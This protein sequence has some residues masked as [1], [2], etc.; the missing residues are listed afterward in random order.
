MF[1]ES[2]NFYEVFFLIYW[3][4]WIREIV[5]FFKVEYPRDFEIE[6]SRSSSCLRN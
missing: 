2:I 3:K 1:G 6:V 4:G 5:I